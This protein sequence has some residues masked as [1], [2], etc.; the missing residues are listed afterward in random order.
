MQTPVRETSL[1]ASRRRFN[2]GFLIVAAAILHVSVTLTVFAI[3]RYQLFPTQVYSTGVG[4]FASDGIIYEGQV[5]ELSNIFKN[6]GLRAWATWPTQLHVRFYSIPLALGSRWISFNI[7]AI[8]PVNLI[9]YLAILALVFKLAESLFGY[10]SGLVAAM[11]VGLWPSF[12]L[13]TTQMLRDPLLISVLLVVVW[14]VVVCLKQ[15]LSWRWGMLL[16]IGTGVA[17]LTIR[18]VRLPVWTLLCIII[19]TAVLLIVAQVI[20]EKRVASGTVAFTIIIIAT[21]VVVPRFQSS[22]RN[23][24]ET[25][26]NRFVIPEEAQKLT[27][28]EQIESRRKGFQYRMD[29][30]GKI[31]PADD[32]SRIDSDIQFHSVGDIIRHVPRAIM[33]GFFAPFPNMWLSAGKQVGFSGRVISGIEMLL[34]YMIES[35]ALFGLWSARKNLS[36]WFLV[37]VIGLG[38]TALGLVV[39]NMGAMYRLRYPFWALLVIL[40]AGGISFLFGR[41]RNHRLDQVDKSSARD[42]SI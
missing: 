20:R 7:L 23:Q 15:K 19:G 3:G 33:I 40:G 12:L 30:E 14:S 39:N 5:V 8:E 21:M 2:L 25:R 18:I 1:S 29:E 10:K 26:I 27:I 34:T 22:F 13:H 37:I 17:I 35:L 31:L 32:G 4:K 24:Q 9:Y 38:A 16:G 41:F 42:F 6:D 28:N 11:I 36:A